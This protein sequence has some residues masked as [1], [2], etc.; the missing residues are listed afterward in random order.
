MVERRNLGTKRKLITIVPH[1][2]LIL[3][4]EESRSHTLFASTP[5]IP[6]NEKNP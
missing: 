5:A 6:A 2:P 1:G 4:K 3:G